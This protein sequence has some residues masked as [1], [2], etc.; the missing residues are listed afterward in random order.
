MT[1]NGER[2]G[3]GERGQMLII[4]ALGLAVLL[5]F[6]AMAIDVGILYRDRRHLQN[7]AD[8]AAL[9]GAAELPNDP[10][11]AKAEAEN[12]ALKHGLSLDQIKTIEVRSDLAAND[13]VH[14]EVEQEFG[15][16]FARVF[17]MT[18]SDVGAKA[19]AR[20]GSLA[21][22]SEFVPWALLTDDTDCLDG[23]GNPVFGA[24]CVVKVGAGD[25]TT[26]WY[27]ALDTDGTGGGSNE[28][29]DGI[30]D[31]DVDWVYCIA[32]DP[33]PGCAGANTTIDALSGDKVGPTDKGIVER[34][35]RGA[36]CDGNGNGIDDRTV[37]G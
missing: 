22:S 32:G 8:A 18:T 14:V 26:G 13:T 21:G 27:G 24:S 10:S 4:F 11:A 31:G 15:W 33:S 23:N 3:R 5:V 17:G 7:T 36:Q 29:R 6:T 1:R 12:W 16:M 28:Y 20:V 34:L 25:A 9:A 19:A 37:H 2:N 30:I 35:A